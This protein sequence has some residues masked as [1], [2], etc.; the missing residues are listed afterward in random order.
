M[1]KNFSEPGYEFDPIGPPLGPGVYVVCIARHDQPRPRKIK[2]VYIGSS[3]NIARRV[4][5]TAHPYRKLYDRIGHEYFV[6]VACM[7][8]R[9]YLSEEIRMIKKWN[10]LLNKAHKSVET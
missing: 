3:A 4:L 9:D 2:P 10:P 5:S 6:A 7:Q 8:T 1:S